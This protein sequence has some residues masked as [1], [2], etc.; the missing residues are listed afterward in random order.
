MF[1]S[2]CDCPTTEIEAGA[3]GLSFSRRAMTGELVLTAP[4][5]LGRLLS[6]RFP[7]FLDAHPGLSVRLELTDRRIDILAERVDIAIRIG[8]PGEPGGANHLCGGADVETEK[9]LG[10]YPRASSV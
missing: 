7:E 4:F 5:V 8:E 3:S 1:R 2:S 9:A 6:R 10:E